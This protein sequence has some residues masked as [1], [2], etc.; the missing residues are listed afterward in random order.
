[1]SDAGAVIRPVRYG[2]RSFDRQWIIPD[3]RLINQPN[4][5]LWETHSSR[6]VYMTAVQAHP[7]SAGPAVTFSA[8]IPDL[9]HYNGRGGRVFPLWADREHRTPNL[10]AE[11]L[12]ELTEVLGIAVGATDLM[13]Y[14]AA[15]AA[16]PAYTERFRPDLLQPGLRFP[17]TADASLF[18]EAFEIGREVIWLHCF[19][20]RFADPGAGHPGGPPRMP[21]GERPIIPTAGSISTRPD[22]FPGSIDYFD[23][24]RRLKV[25]DGFIDNVP[26]AVWEYEVSGKQ[27][28]VQWFSY[29]RRDRSRP[30][31]ARRPRSRR[32]SPAAGSPSTPRS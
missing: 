6:Q 26:P 17:M 21:Q 11:L 31:D 25:G 28:L 15:V 13:A 8:T 32:S 4:P 16:H 24:L 5:T 30:I 1:M 18:A 14:F 20:E 29:R 19:G 7:P 10:K 12:R 27:V 22:H 23:A 2:Y 9:H 3:G